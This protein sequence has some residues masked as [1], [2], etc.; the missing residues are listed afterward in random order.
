MSSSGQLDPESDHYGS[1]PVFYIGQHDS[2][3]QA[4][5]TDTQ[6]RYV[7]DTGVSLGFYIVTGVG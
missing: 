2:A 3:R 5:V 7:V 4:P 1:R 6:Y